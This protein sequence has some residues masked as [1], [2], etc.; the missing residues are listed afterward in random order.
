MEP[1]ATFTH[2]SLSLLLKKTKLVSYSAQYVLVL[3]VPPTSIAESVPSSGRYIVALLRC[4]FT[5]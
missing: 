4:T 2:F 1:P 3:V 5:L